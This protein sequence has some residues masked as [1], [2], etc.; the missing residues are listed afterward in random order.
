[1]F[2]KKIYHILMLL[3]KKRSTHFFFDSLLP[4][5]YFA[6]NLKQDSTLE[7]F[8]KNRS[9][10]EEINTELEARYKAITQKGLPKKSKDLGSFNLPVSIGTLSVDNALLDLGAS[11][12]I[13]PLAMLRKIS[14]LEVQPTKMQLH[15][16]DRSIKYPYGMVGDVLVKVDKFIFPVDF[17]IV[18]MKED[19]EVP[20]ILGR[21]FMK[22]ARIIVDVDKG[23]LQLRVQEEE[24]TF[25]LFYGL[26][27][28]NAGGNAYKRMQQREFFTLK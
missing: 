11:I 19:E 8:R 1:M 25:N 2:L 17:V 6:G 3:Q 14:D 26:K 22:T 28:F 20:L 27:N 15:L 7:R 4:K 18:D 5:N 10:I 21:P 16:V 9:Y 24:V 12:N 23:E 13:M